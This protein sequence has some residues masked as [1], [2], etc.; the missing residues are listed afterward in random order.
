MFRKPFSVKKNTNMRNSDVKKLLQR[1]PEEIR[2]LVPKKALVAHAKFVTFS[3]ATLNVYLVDKD[4]MF[5]DFD[6]AGVLF[7]TIYC[8][9]LAP[10]AFPMVLVHESVLAHLQ[11][12]ADLMLPGIIRSAELP[13]REFARGHVV[14][15]SIRS[16]GQVM[17]PMAVGTALMSSQEIIASNFNGRGIQPLH[18]YRDFL[19]EFGSRVIPTAL[20]LKSLAEAVKAPEACSEEDFPSLGTLSVSDQNGD[21]VVT[22]EKPA[23]V[24]NMESNDATGDVDDEPM[25]QLL[26][27]CFLAALKHRLD[28]LPMDVG[29]FYAQCLLKCVPNGKRLEM[30]KTK[31]KK[32]SA[33]LDEV[34]KSEDGPLVKIRKEGKGCD[35]IEE[36]FKSHPALRSFVVTDEVV[37]DEEAEQSKSGPKI[38]EYFSITENVLPLLKTRGNFS[39]GQ[40]LEGPQIRELVTSYVKSEELN[41]GKYVRL[42]PILAQVTRIPD[43]TTDWNTLMQKIQSKMTKTFVLRMP[44]GRELIRKI[45]MPRIVFKVETRSG[46]KKVTL[47]NNLSAFGIEVKKLCHQIQVEAATSATTTNEAV[48]CEGPQVTVLGNHV[49]YLGDLLSN[50]YGID[51]KYMDGLDLGIKKKRK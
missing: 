42:D 2:E 11:N 22:D 10:M 12:G 24:I 31:Y 33:F 36:V 14:T 1:L 21:A 49:T 25:D 16:N 17:G 7:P 47:I 4:P 27:R 32:F 18:I 40:L 38:Y 30:K 39:K 44:D 28:Q 51:K 46:N 37:K 9:K 34:N 6:A 48:N 35:L 3:G 8:T 5:F 50:E 23:Q 41:Q 43:E 26:Y 15:I 45:N 20:D 13:M 29:Q 19:W